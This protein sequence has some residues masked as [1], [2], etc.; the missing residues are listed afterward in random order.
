VYTRTKDGARL[1]LGVY[2]D[3]LIITGTSSTAIGEFKQEMMSLFRMSDLGLLSYYLGIEVV[4]RPGCI[5]L[6]KQ[7]MP[8]SCS[9]KW[10]CLTATQLQ[11]P[12][13]HD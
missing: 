7:P 8:R 6:G 4:Q 5:R 1:L 2:V 9:T 10:V 11:R 3:D 13:S 12:G